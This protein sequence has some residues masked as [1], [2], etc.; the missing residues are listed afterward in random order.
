MPSL[1]E[2]VLRR[3]PPPF[4]MYF[5]GK[6]C[7]V[8]FGPPAKKTASASTMRVGGER[9]SKVVWEERHPI[10]T[11]SEPVKEVWDG[12]PAFFHRDGE[13][14]ISGKYCRPPKTDLVLPPSWTRIDGGTVSHRIFEAPGDRDRSI[15]T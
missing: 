8:W 3:V 4:S 15:K 2:P 5:A 1:G 9:Y 14:M 6:R 13:R 11:S 10:L 12:S 7:E